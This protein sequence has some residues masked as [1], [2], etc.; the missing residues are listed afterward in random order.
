[1]KQLEVGFI[2][3]GNMASSIIAGLLAKGLPAEQVR[4]CDPDPERLGLLQQLGPIR[5][6]SDNNDAIA[7][8]DIVILAVKPQVM[9]VVLAQT[10]EALTRHRPVTLSIAAGIT[11]DSFE[12][13]LDN[14]QP[15][16]RCMPNTP[17]LLGHGAAALYANPATS[18]AQR[19]IAATIL[20][21]VGSVCWLDR[22]SDLD[23]VTAVSG[24]GPAYFFLL[25]ESMVAAGEALGLEPETARQLVVQTALGA[26]HMAADDEIDLAELRRR[27]TSPGGTTA[28]AIAA[29]E[30]AGFSAIVNDAV[31]SAAVRS[32][33][34]AAELG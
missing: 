8:A 29:F 17:A 12:A 24:S 6:S 25:M 19:E 26:A 18:P 32:R 5:T 31:N 23:A 14:K 28:A 1:M 22:E 27:V 9:S 4:A 13:Q 33:E 3:G 2:G 30:S 11:I 10:Q 21:T 16:V 34:L 7:G 20:T 15:I